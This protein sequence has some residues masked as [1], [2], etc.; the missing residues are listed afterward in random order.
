[1]TTRWFPIAAALQAIAACGGANAPSP[2]A[3]AAEEKVVNVYNW[4]DYVGPTTIGDFEAR[5]GIRVVYDTYDANEILETK[6]L[7]GHSGY[8]VVVPSA[9]PLARQVQAG[10]IA[11][12]DKSR[13]PNLVHT[14]PFVMERIA[15]NDQGNEHAVP[16]MWGTAGLGY[17]PAMVRKAIGT[18]RIDSWRAIFEPAIAAKLARCGLAMMD[19]R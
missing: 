13:L 4:V 12:L 5:T 18:G 3:P 15:L 7:T 9:V 19:V 11:R 1:M 16:Y 17:N 8:D 14:D 10:A 6:M 2:A